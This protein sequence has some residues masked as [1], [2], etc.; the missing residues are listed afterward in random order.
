MVTGAGSGVGQGIIKAL[1]LCQIPK[2]LIAAD[3]SFLNSALFR[4]DE[5]LIIPKVEEE[6]ALEKIIDIIN[7]N[8][9]DVVMIGSEFD[10]LFFAMNKEV[11]QEKSGAFIIVS[12]YETVKI[13]ND[14]WLTAEFLRI[15]NLPYPKTYL[16]GSI[17]DA[18]S[19]AEV[20]GYPVLIKTR[21]GTS[22]RHVSV[23]NNRTQLKSIYNTIPNPIIQQLID[24]PTQQLKQEYTCSV[25]KCANGSLLGPFTARRTLRGGSSWV[26]EVD[27][28]IDL[29]SLL[30]SIGRLLPCMGSLN[31]QLMIG[32]EGPIPF[33]FNARFSGTTAVRA[34]FGFNEPE[35]CLREFILK[36]QVENPL[37]RKGLALRYLE[38]VFLEG[39][40]EQDLDFPIPRG[41]IMRWF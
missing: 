8:R 20:L 29:H 31:I 14:K 36:E 26:I 24:L 11:I 40:T 19:Q 35:F 32:P 7:N 34:Y 5:S 15:N 28:F 41:E 18:M 25:F 23:V 27:N 6:R 21:T 38:E 12:P 37:I 17:D 22:S 4:A 9:I 3:I 16:P 39:I 13:A 10:L 1:R 2:I 33:E 30:I